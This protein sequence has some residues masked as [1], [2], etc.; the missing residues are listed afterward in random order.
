MPALKFPIKLLVLF[1]TFISVLYEANF[2]VVNNQDVR[3][4]WTK[5]S[6]VEAM[7]CVDVE[8]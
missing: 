7:F 3:E 2:D 6:H 5:I 8:F 1:F 4:S